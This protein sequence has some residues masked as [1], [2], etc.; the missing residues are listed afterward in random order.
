MEQIRTYVV[1]LPKDLDRK[2]SI[3]NETHKFPWLDVE[4]I[5]AVYGKELTEKEMACLFDQKSYM[6]YYGRSVLPGEVGCTLSHREC[7]RRLLDS[8]KI[9]VMILEDDACFIDDAFT[10][11]FTK[12]STGFM[13][14]PEPL[15]LLLHANFEYIGGK[16]SFYKDYF[17]Y[18]V[19][20]ALFTTAYL[21]NRS[22]AHILLQKEVPYWVADD[23]R[24]FR[25][26]GIGIYSLYP[27]VIVQQWDT[28][29]STIMEERC[30]CRRRL[31]PHSLIE[32]RKVW[33]KLGYIFLKKLGIIKHLQ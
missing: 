12:A 3:L 11:G 27:S 1:N 21:V 18:P 25:R 22:A 19:Y 9:F 15:I 30:V 32:C 23:W 24:L 2:K 17:L 14:S 6:S 28:F 7:Y 20:S 26:W 5:K 16:T 4:I 13:N 33:D 29:T 8:N 10:E 31:F